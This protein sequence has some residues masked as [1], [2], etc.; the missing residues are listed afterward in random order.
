MMGPFFTIAML[1]PD[2]QWAFRV[3]IVLHQVS[4]FGA[5]SP[6]LFQPSSSRID[7]AGYFILALGIVEGAALIGWRLTQLP[8]SQS[9]EFLLTSPIQPRQLFRAEATVGVLRFALVWL[10]GLP[11]FALLF[12]QRSIGW[13]D[14]LP[15]FLMPFLWGLVLGFGQTA[16]IYEPPTVRRVGEWIALA[17]V[18][19]YLVVGVLAGEK[20]LA[21]LQFVPPALAK[22]L[23]F[24]ALLLNTWNPF[25]V[26]HY[27]FMPDNDPAVA[28]ERLAWINGISIA[29]AL[30]FWLRATYR[31][32]GHFHD[33]HYRPSYTNRADLS[34]QIG[35]RPLSWWAVRR[36]MEYSGRVNLWLAGGFCLLYALYITAGDDWPVWLGRMVFVAFDKFGGAPVVA[37]AMCVMAGVPAV[38]Q[39]GLWDPSVQARCLRLE[40]LLLTDLDSNDYMHAAFSAAWKRGRGYLFAAA[41]LW[42]GMGLSGQADWLSVIMA[43]VGGLVYWLLAFAVGFTLF[44]SGNMS[45]G[46]ASFFTLGLPILLYV[47]MGSPYE[48]LAFFVPTA[49]SYF[50]LVSSTGWEWLVVL[51]LHAS[52]AVVLLKLSL[53]RC[54]IGLRDWYDR[55]HGQANTG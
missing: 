48:Q 21:W 7:F 51:A 46:V 32:S 9:L 50:P 45:N 34:Y 39:Y 4:L 26:L 24:V 28:V 38:F 25:A 22:G 11:I 40:L 6:L 17:G 19:V 42:L 31:L 47:V 49:L 36:V 16:W 13:A 35:N 54:V 1:S 37:T 30:L 33:R 3:A 55:N 14:L 10:S 41:M 8:K 27:W 23:V 5:V 12:A 44:A 43:G 29:L 53:A 2:R 20:L 52:L 18:I 15:L